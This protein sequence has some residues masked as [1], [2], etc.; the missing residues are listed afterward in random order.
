MICISV[1]SHGQAA[2][3]A[4]FLRSLAA[5]PPGVIKRV[6]LTRN[7]AE[8]E[9]EPI[10][11]GPI[12]LT[13][14]VPPQPRGFGQNHNTAFTLCTEPFFC[15]VNPDIVL[16]DD[17]F[18]ELLRCIEDSSIG[19]VAPL[20]TTPAMKIENTARSLYTPPE[21][22]RQKIRAQNRGPHADWLAGMF[23]FFRS[24]AYRSIGGFDERYFLYIEDVDICTR[25]RLAGWG[26][27]QCAR[28]SV[29]HDARKQ[30]HRS[31]K[32]TSWHIAG[33]LRYWASPTFWRYR[34]SLRNQIESA[35][36]TNGGE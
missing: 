35:K 9:L 24:E 6:I 11:L 17:P 28:S 26:L 13:T 31:L 2:I 12:I 16:P 7:I 22:I 23:M 29:I 34:A 33:M 4:N 30:S 1:V 5:L 19:L 21:L 27:T 36:P 18:P 25:L 32:Y 15:V 10:D 14:I 3:V 20:V 8:P